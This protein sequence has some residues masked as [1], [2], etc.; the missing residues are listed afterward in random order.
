MRRSVASGASCSCGE[1]GWRRRLSFWRGISGS[2]LRAMRIGR[3]CSSGQMTVEFAVVFPVLLMV[4]FISVNALVFLG[5]CAAFDIVA[6]DAIRLQADD[7]QRE[8]QG[9]AETCA[10]IER[11]LSM[12][13]E[14]VSVTSE[15]TAAGHIRY[16]ARTAFSPPFLKGVR[17]FGIAVP[18]LE[19]EVAF[20][21]SPYRAG[22]VV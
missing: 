21:V 6:R 7:G 11:G 18:P 12:E 22:V 8:A 1:R 16:V 10:R 5:D 13:H 9:C 15:R 2:C 17:V 4:G 19:H 20:V 14:T 3:R